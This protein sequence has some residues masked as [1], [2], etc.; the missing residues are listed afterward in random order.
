MKINVVLVRSEYPA[1]IGS[2][3][4]ALA[5]MGGDRLIL[6]DPQCEPNE[7][8]QQM[9]AGAQHKLQSLTRYTS[10]Q[11]FYASEGEGLRIGLTRRC[12]YHR[13]V[14]PLKEQIETLSPEKRPEIIYL[15]FGPEADGLSSDDLA[16][17]NWVC[18]LPVFGDFSSLNLAQAVLLGLYILRS[19]FGEQ[20][21]VS[22]TK[23]A[24]ATPEEPLYFPEQLIKDWLTAMG[25]NVSARKASAFLTLRRLFL[26]NLP[27]R[28]EIQVLEAILQQNIRKLRAIRTDRSLSLTPEDGANDITDITGE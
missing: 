25:F 19:H 2:A 27:T 6:I 16:K 8:A 12:G 26:M 28:H 4:R 9:A 11:E 14:F 15:V 3:A 20:P 7:Q 23:G 10:W 5:N 18:H 21:G 17:L 1:N 13:K 22:Q 24:N